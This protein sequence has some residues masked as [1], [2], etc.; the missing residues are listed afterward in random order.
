M[1]TLGGKK[2]KK[3]AIKI[4]QKSPNRKK[5][6]YI[7]GQLRLTVSIKKDGSIE[8]IELDQS[9]GHKILDEAAKH[10]V[11]IG[12]PYAKF[13]DEIAKETDILSITRTWTFTREEQVMTQE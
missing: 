4:N 1:W 7:Y 9:S 8:N 3:S 13:T 10:I 2:W 5:Y 11:E 6:I 12:A